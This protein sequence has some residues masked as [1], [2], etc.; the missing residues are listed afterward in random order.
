MYTQFLQTYKGLSKLGTSQLKL[1]H[2][3]E[4][5]FTN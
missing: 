2:S 1:H 3:I 4:E 5:G